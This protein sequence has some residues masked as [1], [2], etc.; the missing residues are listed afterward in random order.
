MNKQ[1]KTFKDLTFTPHPMYICDG[2]TAR[3]YFDNGYG[4]SV[5]RFKIPLLDGYGSFTD[6]EEEWECAILRLKDGEWEVC[7]D[8]SITDDVIGYLL[9]DDVTDLMFKIQSLDKDK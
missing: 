6:N 1:M 7:F 8:T 4:I 3:L 5:V 9:A 2:L